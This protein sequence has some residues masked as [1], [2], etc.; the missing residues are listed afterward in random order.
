MRKLTKSLFLTGAECQRKL[1]YQG[2]PNQY[3][4]SKTD[5]EF[6]ESLADG[7]FQVGALARCYFPEGRL[8][9]TKDHA[10]AL[11]QTKAALDSGDC[12][13]FEA[14]IG[15]GNL[16]A[17]IDILRKQGDVIELIEVKAKSFNGG[18]GAH[19]FL[20]QNGAVAAAWLPY[21]LDIAFQTHVA[22]LQFGDAYKIT[23]HLMLADKEKSAS[24]EG[25]NQM[26]KVRKTD[27]TGSG[28]KETEVVVSDKL[29]QEHLSTQIL[30]AVDVSSPC[31]ILFRE[32]FDGKSFSE[33][34]QYLAD[35]YNADTKLAPMVSSGCRGCEFKNAGGTS[36]PTGGFAECMQETFSIEPNRLSEPTIFDLWDNRK[37]NEMLVDGT[38]MV[39]DLPAAS[40]AAPENPNEGLTAMERKV[41]QIHFMQKGKSSEGPE[42]FVNT[43]RL[44]EVMAEWKFPLHFIDFE[45]TTVA[46]PFL[47]GQRPYATTAFQ[48]SHHTVDADGTVTHQGESIIGEPGHFPNFEFLRALKSQLENDQGT[49][50]CFAPHE[51]TVLRHIRQQLMDAK[52]AD[53]QELC[54]FIETLARPST[55]DDPKWNPS[56]QMVDLREIILRHV[57]EPFTGGSNSIKQV[58]PAMLR[59]STFLQ[60]KY[61]KPIYGAEGGISSKNFKDQTWVKRNGDEI[62]NPYDLLPDLS[63]SEAFA[64]FGISSIKNGGA[65]LTA[66]GLLQFDDMKEEQRKELTKALLMY[67]ELDTLA[68]V[69]VY[70]GL[71]EMGK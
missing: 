22:K 56:R 60:E 36:A 16:F 40:F 70:E 11:A 34:V 30:T 50:F 25:L 1:F 44:G 49:V 51:N 53:W 43:P 13:L 12:V 41:M 10:E 55:D 24:A 19:T 59:R 67:C 9:E 14:A 35:A 64:D 61:S 18:E 20:T 42:Y 7:G 57:Y 62:V 2:K 29:S 71:R 45:T 28:R 48:F 31:E 8:I 27:K 68:M 52:P 58:L 17:R 37:A 4:S 63:N 39:S 32:S 65:A 15:S 26:F 21:V 38:L 33:W 5:D 23:S 66:Y 47:K 46:I 69:M 6:L 3:P 54:T